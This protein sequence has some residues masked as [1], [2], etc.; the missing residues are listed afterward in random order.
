VADNFKVPDDVAA[1]LPDHRVF[2]ATKAGV[3][4]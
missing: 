2:I 3:E 4:R 1:R